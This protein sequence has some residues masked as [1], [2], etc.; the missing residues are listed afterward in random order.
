M[1]SVE[2]LQDKQRWCLWLLEATPTELHDSPTLHARLGKV[3]QSRRGSPTASVREAADTPALFTQIRQPSSW[4]FAIPEVSSASREYIP[5]AF[6]PQ[7]VIAG[8]KLLTLP[9]AQMWVF[10]VLQSAMWMAWVRT[11]VGRLKS[12]YSVAPDLAYNAFAFPDLSG[13]ARQEIETAAERMPASRSE[14]PEASLADLYG[15]FS[16]PP[17]LVHAHRELDKAI[18]AAYGRQRLSGDASR[19]RV[20]FARC[21]TQN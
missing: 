14:H 5:A 4:Y 10:G 15:P 2:F 21:R 20:L 8:N 11:V 16:M 9:A 13:K 6:L 1:Q 19:L 18:D 12:D 3:R 7:E 17:G